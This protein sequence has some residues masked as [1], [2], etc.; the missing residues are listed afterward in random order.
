MKIINELSIA[1]SHVFLNG[2]AQCVRDYVESAIYLS[3]YL[4]KSLSRIKRQTSRLAPTRCIFLYSFSCP[5]LLS[6][7][8][9]ILVK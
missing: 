7:K 8:L 5:F 4:Q 1:V 6:V 9:F 3:P 2:H